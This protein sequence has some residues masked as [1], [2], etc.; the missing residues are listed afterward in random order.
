GAGLSLENYLEDEE[1]TA[2]EFETELAQGVRDSIV[3]QFVLDQLVEENEIS[4]DD[5]E[6][7]EHIMRRA[8]Q[9]GQDAN[10]YIQHIMEHNHVPEMVSE[11]LRGKAL[12]SLVESAKVTDASGTVLDL[13][14]L[15]ADG[16]LASEDEAA[17]SGSDEAGSDDAG[18]D[19]AADDATKE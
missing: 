3:A 5:N 2:E 16:S 9:S 7:T 18:S 11:V 6:L 14:Q 10:S 17:E 1:K 15:R 12:A 8:Q 13:S 19:E 4:L